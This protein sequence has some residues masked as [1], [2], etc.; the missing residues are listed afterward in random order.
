MD[1]LE[2]D[3]LS[4]INYK[5]NYLSDPRYM[6]SPRMT[7]IQ[8][9]EIDH[10]LSDHSQTVCL[11]L[12]IT[13]PVDI[14]V[15]IPTKEEMSLVIPSLGIGG[16][17][18]GDSEIRLFLDPSHPNVVESVDQR[19]T[20][21]Q[22]HELNHIARNNQQQSS[23]R[24]LAD[25]LVLEG[26]ATEYEENVGGEYQSTPWGSALSE[27]QI[28]DEWN[29]AVLELTSETYDRRE[30]LFGTSGGHPVWTGYSLGKAI[31]GEYKKRHPDLQMRDLV[32]IPTMEIINEIFTNLPPA[33]K[34]VITTN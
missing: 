20:R 27:E 15:F 24:T 4:Q 21:L 29:K 18:N 25:L 16:T 14:G 28:G 2:V 19:L 32:K 12:G 13:S 3:K 23:H 33:W 8:E 22:A 5:F 9:L 10:R 26:L 11:E 31:V 34:P 6:K 7:E 17:S 1:I 30:W